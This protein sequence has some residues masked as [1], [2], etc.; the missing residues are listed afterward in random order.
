VVPG[1]ICS[2]TEAV[3]EHTWLRDWEQEAKPGRTEMLNYLRKVVT[4][5]GY[6]LSN[7]SGSLQLI[8]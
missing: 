6:R 5:A 8:G 1:V 2:N 7:S 4:R 3:T